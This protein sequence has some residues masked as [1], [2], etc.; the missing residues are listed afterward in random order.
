MRK[1]VRT[2]WAKSTKLREAMSHIKRH[3]EQNIELMATAKPHKI[4]VYCEYLSALDVLEVGIQQ[5]IP[6]QPILCSDGQSSSN[7]RHAAIERFMEDPKHCIVLI[8]FNAGSE[9]IDLSSADYFLLLHPIWN[10]TQI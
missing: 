6:N 4:A 1:A 9:V 2:E 3:L 7:A 5:E 10:P 8:T